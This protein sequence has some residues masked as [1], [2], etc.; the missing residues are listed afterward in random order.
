MPRQNNLSEIFWLNLSSGKR[1][2]KWI[3]INGWKYLLSS[4]VIFMRFPTCSLIQIP[5]SSCWSL[6]RTSPFSSIYH[7]LPQPSFWNADLVMS[8]SASKAINGSLLPPVEGSK[9]HIMP[10]QA[11]CGLS[12]M[13]SLALLPL[14]PTFNRLHPMSQPHQI[15]SAFSALHS[16]AAAASFTWD[17]LPW[18]CLPSWKLTYPLRLQMCLLSQSLLAGVNL[19]VP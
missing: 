13:T 14:T 8:L 4:K 12:Q 5:I 16:S 17:T 3:S 15:C 19:S 2:T 10:F 1:N 18:S 9:F 11:L 7:T 6:S